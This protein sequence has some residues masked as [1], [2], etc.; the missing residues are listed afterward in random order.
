MALVS[1]LYSNGSL[2]VLNNCL[3]EVS[4]NPPLGSLYFASAA[5]NYMTYPSNTVFQANTP[6][7]LTAEAW[8]YPLGITASMGIMGYNDVSPGN[9]SNAGGWMFH[10]ATTAGQLSFVTYQNDAGTSTTTL[11]SGTNLVT[12]NAWNHVAVTVSGTT[13]KL[14]LNGTNVGSN[15]IGATTYGNAILTIAAWNYSAPR[16][17]NGYMTDI[18]ISNTVV[19]TSNFTAPT[20]KLT[21]NS[22]T[23]ILFNTP[24]N[25]PTNS[26]FFDSSPYRRDLT[27][28]L[29]YGPPANVSSS[30]SLTYITPSLT[31]PPQRLNSNGL[32]Q[33]LGGFDEVTSL[34]GQ[35]SRL[36]SNG[37][38]NIAGNFDEVSTLV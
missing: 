15:T 20:T 23:Q 3:D 7:G 13:G 2:L 9:V 5:T 35:A 10:I 26:A 37:V 14:W 29:A 34:T 18:R 36:F 17:F 8:I 6:G 32:F 31:S 38:L 25:L 1:R 27:G 12:N 4:L 28:L 21:A 22:S 24:Y 11:N 19:Y 33:V 16:L 30:P